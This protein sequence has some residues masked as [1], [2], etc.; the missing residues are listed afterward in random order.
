[1]PQDDAKAAWVYARP[2]KSRLLS[3]SIGR[4]T[5]TAIAFAC[6]IGAICA[7]WGEELNVG[8]AVAFS[9]LIVTAIMLDVLRAFSKRD[10]VYGFS[11]AWKLA[12]AVQAIMVTAIIGVAILVLRGSDS[13]SELW[14]ILLKARIGVP[15]TCAMLRTDPKG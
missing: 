4:Q 3:D 15:L 14:S 6:L 9:G 11:L 13:V 2:F 8:A 10:P 1:M 5:G 7:L 12:L